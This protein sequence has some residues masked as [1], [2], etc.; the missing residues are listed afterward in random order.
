MRSLLPTLAEDLGT[1]ER[2]LR[3]ATQRG[4][5]RSRRPGPRQLVL[6][7]GELEYLRSHWELLQ[8]LTQVLRTERSVRLAVLYGSTARGDDRPYSDIDLLVSLRATRAGATSALARRLE[9][10]LGRRDVDVTD[11]GLIEQDA[12]LLLLHALDEGRVLVDREARWPAL[13]ALRGKVARAAKLA[14]RAELRAVEESWKMLE[15][16][17]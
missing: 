16:Y 15:G 7:S 13:I 3:R 14:E 1:N 5:I 4:A 8:N 6:D 12:P 17:A 11:L 2:T 10:A 9:H